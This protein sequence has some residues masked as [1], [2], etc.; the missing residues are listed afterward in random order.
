MKYELLTITADMGGN[1]TYRIRVTNNCSNKMLYTAFQVPDGLVA[2]SPDNF[3]T[4]T[5]PSGNTY[6]VRSPNLA[7]QYSIRYTSMSDS[8]QNG[9]SDIFKYTLPAQANVTYIHVISRLETSQYLE[10]HLNTFYCPIGVT[11][12]GG[13]DR[14]NGERDAASKELRDLHPGLVLFPNPTSADLFVDLSAWQDQTLKVQVLDSRGQRV[15]TLQLPGG[16]EAQM[17][18]LPEA[19]P[20]GLYFVEILTEAGEK[21]SA[22]FVRQNP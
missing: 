7:P 22:R 15:K 12:P 1:R 21:F 13:G 16:G 2:M 8:L 17:L 4:Y 19:L 14:P 5:A 9:E 11:P 6:R 20:G 3:A 10:A 18:E